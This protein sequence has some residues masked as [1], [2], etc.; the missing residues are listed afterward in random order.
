[1]NETASLSI[2]DRALVTQNKMLEDLTAGTRNVSG[3]G[4][5]KVRSQKVLR[6]Q[7]NETA[8]LSISDRALVTLEKMLEDLTAGIRSVSGQGQV[9]VR[10]QKGRNV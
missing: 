6:K 1:M 10:S 3:Q 2:S 9:K 8:S 5:V 4:Q 7:V